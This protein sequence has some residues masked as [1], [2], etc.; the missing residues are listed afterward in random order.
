MNDTL[1]LILRGLI[2]L[3]IGLV[4]VIIYLYVERKVFA[5]IHVRLGPMRV[6]K[7]GVLQPIADAL[8]LLLKEDIIPAK[9]DR[10]LFILAPVIVF[11]PSIMIYMVVPLTDNVIANDL[12]LGIFYIFG[13]LTIVPIGVLIAGWASY[14]KYSLLGG[15]RAAAQ[16]ISYEIPLLLSVLG[17]VM[18]TG[19]MDLRTIVNQQTGSLVSIGNVGIIPNWFVFLQPLGFIIYF[20][21][22]LADQFRVPFDIP[23]AESEL[24]QGYQTEYSSMKFGFLQLAEYSNV[25]VLSAVGVLLFFGGWHGPF[26]PPIIWFF[27]KVWIG[28]LLITWIRMTLPRVRVDQLMTFGWKLLL[29]LTLANIALTGFLQLYFA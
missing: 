14:S 7:H 12:D 23:E 10:L 9:A 8:K 29:P 1:F 19:S 24:V 17:V 11:A 15:L 3:A 5:D 4:N 16:Q 6:G 22:L 26:L 18:I 13:V 27:I 20:I 25:L 28:I 21:T 2:A